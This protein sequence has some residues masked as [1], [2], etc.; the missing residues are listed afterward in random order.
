MTVTKPPAGK[1]LKQIHGTYLSPAEQRKQRLI[2]RV[3]AMSEEDREKIVN[4]SEE[5]A[6]LCVIRAEEEAAKPVELKVS[7]TND[8]VKKLVESHQLPKPMMDEALVKEFLTYV[9]PTYTS[10]HVH[11]H[12]DVNTN[13]VSPMYT[14]VPGTGTSTTYYPVSGKQKK[15]PIYIR[16]TPNSPVTLLGYASGLAA[17]HQGHPATSFMA[18]PNPDYVEYVID[19]IAL[20]PSALHKLG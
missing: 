10:A 11:G 5:W 13:D 12:W 8:W 9:P 3:R 2:R 14:S 1:P 19:M 16:M 6:I 18:S 20:D 7:K 17:T 4:G 15:I